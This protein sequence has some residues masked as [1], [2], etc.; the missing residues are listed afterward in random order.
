MDGF[1]DEA[2]QTFKISSVSGST[3]D[4]LYNAGLW[5][6]PARQYG[7]TV[8]SET[9]V[10]FTLAAD[11]WSRGGA[12]IALLFSF[13][14]ALVLTTAEVAASRLHR[15]GEAAAS[16]LA[17]PVAKAAF[18]DSNFIP[19]LPMLRGLV[20]YPLV[21]ALVVVAVEVCR[22]VVR[23]SRRHNAAVVAGSWRRG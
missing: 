10:E 9:S 6:A 15:F 16:I 12:P 20:L 18:F 2:V 3:P 7:F 21:V 1:L 4:D 22:H 8:N 13:F 17:L 5:N 11:G 19:L 14:A 23:T